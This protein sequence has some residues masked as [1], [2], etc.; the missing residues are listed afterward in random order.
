VCESP[1]RAYTRAVTFDVTADAYDR[2][3]GRFSAPLADLFVDFAGVVPRNH[4]LDVGCGPGALTAR[5]VAR[6]GAGAVAAV[7]PS[8]SFVDAARAR[9]PGVDVRP[10]RAE[11]LPFADGS[12]DVALAQ[13]VVHF[14]T[15]PVAG[16]RE[17]ARVLR[18][19]GT[20]AA[21]V[22]DYGGGT[23]P[24]SLFWR[25]AQDLDPDAVGEDHLPGTREG[26]LVE[27]FGQAGLSA[28]E[29][30]TLT[31]RLRFDS[32]EAWWDPFT[33]GVGPAGGYVAGLDQQRR[34][35]LAARCAE[36]LGP[37]PF[38]TGASAWSVRATAG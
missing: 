9:F 5:L 20:V 26:H 12:F 31:V 15:D 16:L 38:E 23:G 21:A 34:G 2:F 30:A 6:L 24:L 7:D 33:L 8:S 17:M 27:L 10:G 25:A 37:A 35:A 18:P 29:A 19:A 32:F 3:M 11:D 22:W 4:A 28:V 36:L 1:V 14:M 13:L